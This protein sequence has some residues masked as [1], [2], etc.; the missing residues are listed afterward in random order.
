MHIKYS[1]GYIIETIPLA[2]IGLYISSL[3][4]INKLKEERFK[5]ILITFSFIFILFKYDVFQHVKGFGKQG[6]G[7]NIGGCLFFIL[8][9]LLPLDNI[10][11]KISIIFK[12]ITNFTPGIYMVHLPVYKI[13]KKIN[14]IKHRNL[15]SCIYI[16]L[17]SY[18]ICFFGYNIFKNTKLK[19]LFI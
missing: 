18:L 12:H 3:N 10:S 13:T 5:V 19:N 2:V 15:L 14:A 4:I 17:I 9:S 11:K 6:F 7:Y 8:F 1:V 16:Y